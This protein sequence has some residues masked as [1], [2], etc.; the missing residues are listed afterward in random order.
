MAAVS[1]IALNDA[2]ATPVTHTFVPSKQGLINGGTTMQEWEERT[3]Y[4]GTPSGFRRIHLEF[5]R[6]NADRKTYRVRI[7]VT[8]PFLNFNAELDVYE[9]AWQEIVDM[10]F[11]IP[12]ASSLASRKDVRK[13][14]YEL[15]NNSHVKAALE[16][17][18]TP[19]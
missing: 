3:F 12:T 14:A 9:Q 4:D 16:D 8:V 19:Y 11:T 13:F 17:L 18:D 1:S 10:S 5:S 6:P 2:Q 7:Q 15:L